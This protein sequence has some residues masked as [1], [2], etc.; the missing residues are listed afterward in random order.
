[1]KFFNS[2]YIFGLYNRALWP[3]KSI[4]ST[5]SHHQFL[6]C[7]SYSSLTTTSHGISTELLQNS[8]VRS[9]LNK[10]I[11]EDYS[12]DMSKPN[13]SALISAIRLLKVDLQSL[14]EFDIEKEKDKEFGEQLQ[15]EIK[16]HEEQLTKLELELLNS[17]VPNEE[18]NCQDV[19]LEITAG[20][21]GQ[22]AMIFTLELFEMYNSFAHYRGWECEVADYCHTEM[23]GIRHACLMLSG[24][25]CYSLLQHEGGVHRVQRVPKTE[26]S[27][28]IHTS[29]VTVAILPQ[30]TELDVVINDRDLIIETKRASGAGGQHVNKTDSAIRMHHKP[31]GVVVECQTDRS[32]IKNRKLALQKLRAIIYKKQL[33]QQQ[34]LTRS[35]RKQQVGSSGRSEK[36]RTYNFNQDRITDHRLS[37][38]FHNL[39][40]F[41]EGR[42]YL[43]KVVIELQER[44][45]KILFNEFIESISKKN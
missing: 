22:E 8:G 6:V 2:R 29:T 35:A 41:L 7:R 5:L 24:S 20:V 21:G 38:S 33:E 31:T 28:R 15:K 12:E 1:M 25:D 4:Q 10:L 36:I 43:D 45:N 27:G 44:A 17:L 18:I 37:K 40:G 26:K 42:E 9:Y 32:Q 13:V 3:I 11:S 14:N 39:V 16:S 30:P 19:M 34:S 23:G